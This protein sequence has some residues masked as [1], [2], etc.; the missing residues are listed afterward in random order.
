LRRAVARATAHATKQIEEMVE[1][2]EAMAMI[3]GGV[4]GWLPGNTGGDHAQQDGQR[5]RALAAALKNN[6]AIKNFVE[7]AGRFKRIQQRKQ[8][9]KVKHGAD[10]ISDIVLGSDINRLLPSEVMQ[11]ANKTTKLE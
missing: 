7:L 11:L 9:E 2:E 1:A 4:G 3:G 5:I 6:R 8:R 10:E